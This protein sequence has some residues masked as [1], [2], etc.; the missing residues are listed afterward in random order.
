M[1]KTKM[2]MHYSGGVRLPRTICL[3]GYPACCSGHQAEKIKAQGNQTQLP[4]AVTCKRCLWLL[5]AA[6]GIRQL[7]S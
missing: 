5:T 2:K 1:P 7:F 6:P 3:A 4:K